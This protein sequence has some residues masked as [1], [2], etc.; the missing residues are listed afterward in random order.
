MPMLLWHWGGIRPRTT[1]PL[2]TGFIAKEKGAK[3]IS[4]DPRFTRTSSKADVYAPIRSGTDVAF[5]GGMIKYVLDDIEANQPNY[6]MI[7]ITEYTNAPFLIN[8][9]F[10]GPAEL[11]GLFS[12]YAGS[13]NE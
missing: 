6:N 13:L 3:L 9:D 10:K 8:P 7:Y 1:R 12:G 4:I 5:V 2:F 11:E